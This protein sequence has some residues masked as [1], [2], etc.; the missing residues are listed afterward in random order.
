MGGKK[1]N[2]VVY[3][4]CISIVHVY[5]SKWSVVFHFYWEI[6]VQMYGMYQAP[7]IY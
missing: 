6:F 3:V 2:T 5:K 1:Q 7:E 4:I